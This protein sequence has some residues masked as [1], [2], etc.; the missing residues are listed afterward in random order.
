MKTLAVLTVGAG[1][2][3]LSFDPSKPAEV[4]RAKTIVE[5]MLKRGFAILVEV[6]V[7]D[8]RPLYQRAVSFDPATCEYLVVG[9][10][11]E[12]EAVADPKPRKKYTR[13]FPAATTGA[14]AVARSAGG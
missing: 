2:T 13:R 12:S 10:P 6:G 11:E 8:G 4:A 14:V 7:K 9:T 3:K 5:D 1:D